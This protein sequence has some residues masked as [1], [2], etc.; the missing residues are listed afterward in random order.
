MPYKCSV[1]GCRSNYDSVHEKVSLFQLPIDL[2]KKTTWLSRIQLNSKATS[3]SRVCIKHFKPE[4]IDNSSRRCILKPGAVP[5]ASTEVQEGFVDEQDAMLTEESTELEDSESELNSDKIQSFAHFCEGIKEMKI[6]D[7]NIYMKHDGIC[8][9]HLT[10]DENFNDVEMTFKILINKNMRVKLCKRDCE[11]NTE[12]LNWVLK[13]CHLQKWSQLID[14]MVH[15]QPEPEIIPKT[16]PKKYLKKAYNILQE[17]QLNEMQGHVDSLKAHLASLYDFANTMQD[18]EEDFYTQPLVEYIDVAN[19]TS[20]DLEEFHVEDDEISREEFEEEEKQT[21][22]A[23]V[24]EEQ[25]GEG[26]VNQVSALIQCDDPLVCPK[27]S[28]KFLSASGLR[29]HEKT[30]TTHFPKIY[31]SKT[32]E[33]RKN[34]QIEMNV[35]DIC[36]KQFSLMKG[37]KEHMKLHDQNLRKKCPHCGIIIYSGILQRHIRAVHEKSKPYEW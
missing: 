19:E 17:I 22:E 34:S 33:E 8:F 5:K 12:E 7:W 10:S 28:I 4:D 29:A 23:E 24:Y 1:K 36:G 11:S 3:F 2:E 18:I 16:L 20:E 35:C 21:M 6:D 26:T 31:K 25:P 15:Y 30:C 9:Y 13:D 37:L 27:C 14:I 32:V